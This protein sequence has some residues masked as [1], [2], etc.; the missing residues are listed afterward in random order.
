MSR[1]PLVIVFGRYG[2][3]RLE[4]RLRVF[5]SLLG[6]TGVMEGV[7]VTRMSSRV[8]YLVESKC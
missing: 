6:A 2:Y 1:A 5:L 8:L 7:V 3:R 4:T